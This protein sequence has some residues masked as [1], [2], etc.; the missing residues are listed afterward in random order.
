MAT[1]AA[2]GSEG[3][4][5]GYVHRAHHG[6]RLS[7]WLGGENVGIGPTHVLYLVEGGRAAWV[8]ERVA[9]RSEDDGSGP[10]TWVP[11]G[12][13]RLLADALVMVAVVVQKHAGIRGLI[14]QKL[15]EKAPDFFESEFVDLT[16][17]DGDLL[18]EI[19]NAA[20]AAVE[21]KLVVT[22]MNGSSVT[23]QL[24]LLGRCSMVAE[25]C[26]ASWIRQL[27]VDGKLQTAGDLPPEDPDAH[28]F[29]AVRL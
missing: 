29:T 7:R 23:G 20:A 19:E 5:S 22:V 17:V 15:G 14:E 18:E 10:V 3:V 27:D 2:A 8:L 26:M 25:V 24:A 11:H 13:D 21:P 16:E 6:R 4:E 28:L 1:S 9:H 12:P